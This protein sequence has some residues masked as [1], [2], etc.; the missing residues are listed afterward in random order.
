MEGVL[1]LRVFG[2]SFQSWGIAFCLP[3]PQVNDSLCYEEWL[4]I[5][6]VLRIVCNILSHFKGILEP[7]CPN[8]IYGECVC[9]GMP[10]IGIITNS[11]LNYDDKL[12]HY[13]L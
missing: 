2:A 8:A 6:K 10:F 7:V 9:R 13:F 11:G 12:G 1:K 5:T 3:H 4:N